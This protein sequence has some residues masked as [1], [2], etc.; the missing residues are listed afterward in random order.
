M[1]WQKFQDPKLLDFFRHEWIGFIGGRETSFLEDKQ[2]QDVATVDSF[3]VPVDDVFSRVSDSVGTLFSFVVP[4]NQCASTTDVDDFRDQLFL[5]GLERRA[6]HVGIL[7]KFSE[8]SSE[9]DLRVRK[10][11]SWI[12]AED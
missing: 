5:E 7:H 8:G 10:F 2:R 1:S 12:T 4:V 9:T 6:E 3:R 11:E